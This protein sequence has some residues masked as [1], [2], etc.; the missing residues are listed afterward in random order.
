MIDFPTLS[1]NSACEIPTRFINL[2]PE[3]K[4]PFSGGASLYKVHVFFPL[5]VQILGSLRNGDG[6]EYGKKALGLVKQ[7][8]N[9]AR[10]SPF[11]VHFLAIVARLQ[12]GTA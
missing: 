6:Y 9:F 8:N 3:K 2:K 10:A 1:Y 4:V 12:R 5:T 11:F 7:N